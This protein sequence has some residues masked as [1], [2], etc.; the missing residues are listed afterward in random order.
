M[1]LFSLM[2]VHAS[3]LC[4]NARSLWLQH[5]VLFPLCTNL[6]L[7]R[8]VEKS[9]SCWWEQHGGKLI[10]NL[11]INPSLPVCWCVLVRNPPASKKMKNQERMKKLLLRLCT[12]EE[13]PSNGTVCE[14]N[15]I[16]N[17][18]RRIKST[19]ITTI[20]PPRVPKIQARR[21]QSTAQPPSTFLKLVNYK[22]LLDLHQRF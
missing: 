8:S 5:L 4:L 17:Q 3:L 10:Q 2:V 20:H 9:S 22:V 21:L 13:A 16:T 19:R 15:M 1:C 14:G 7:K 18:I 12:I 11:H 6:R